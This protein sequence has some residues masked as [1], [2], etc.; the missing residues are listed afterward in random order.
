MNSAGFA[1]SQSGKNR[2]PAASRASGTRANTN[3]IALSA[4]TDLGERDTTRSRS[5]EFLEVHP[6]VEARYLIAVAVEEH[7]LPSGEEIGD[8]SLLLLA[9]V[10]VVDGWVHVRVK[11][12]LIGV[13]VLSRGLRLLLDEANSYDR[14]A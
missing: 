4:L 3:T 13:G 11:A 14:L 1:T 10:R 12:V 7:C 8:A 5:E 2:A 9:L 6:G